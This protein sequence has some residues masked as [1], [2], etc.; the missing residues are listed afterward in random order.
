MGDPTSSAAILTL[1]SAA[2]MGVDNGLVYGDVAT[3]FDPFL[4]IVHAKHIT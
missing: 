3:L 1:F 2:T 4:L